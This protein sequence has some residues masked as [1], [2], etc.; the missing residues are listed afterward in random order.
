VIQL[1]HQPLATGSWRTYRW[2]VR[3]PAADL[4]ETFWRLMASASPQF[5][6]QRLGRPA[7][8]QQDD[9]HDSPVGQSLWPLGHCWKSAQSPL[10]VH[11]QLPPAATVL[12]EHPSEGSPQGVWLLHGSPFGSQLLQASGGALD[13]AC[14]A[15]PMLS[16]VGAAQTATPT[17][18][19]FSAVRRE[20]ADRVG[21]AP[22]S[23]SLFSIALILIPVEIAK[24]LALR[25]LNRVAPCGNLAR[26]QSSEST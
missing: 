23:S 21:S 26:N 9:T 14:A 11:R 2:F 8:L 18:A 5:G 10:V 6:R 3:G 25:H 13:A 15:D 4:L 12:Q 16:T 24:T 20:N 7:S 22:V 17:P 19:P 1:D